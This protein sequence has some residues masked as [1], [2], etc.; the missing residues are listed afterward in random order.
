MAL[1]LINL[2][3]QKLK[4][5][6]SV[7]SG[8]IFLSQICAAQFNIQFNQTAWK[9]EW[10]FTWPI[11][12]AQPFHRHFF[13]SA[14]DWLISILQ[15]AIL[16][17]KR[18]QLSKCKWKYAL[19]AFS[20]LFIS[21]DWDFMQSVATSRIHINVIFYPKDGNIALQIEVS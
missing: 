3:D 8:R 10:N 16:N 15:S 14:H 2:T 7:R 11:V 12:Q 19:G 21:S 1:D 20:A 9:N 13:L 4:L 5:T 18:Q 17:E 6:K